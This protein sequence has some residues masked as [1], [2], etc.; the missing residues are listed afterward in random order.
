MPKHIVRRLK[1]NDKEWMF[2][3]DMK[4]KRFH[5]FAIRELQCCMDYVGHQIAAAEPSRAVCEASFEG[6]S[7]R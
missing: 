7:T 4:V 1:R 2:V 6:S 3:S 5:A